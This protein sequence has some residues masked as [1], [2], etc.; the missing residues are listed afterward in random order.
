MMCEMSTQELLSEFR[1][2]ERVEQYADQ[3]NTILD[4]AFHAFVIALMMILS[5]LIDITPL[6]SKCFEIVGS[7]FM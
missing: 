2:I 4:I 5:E 6:L 3:N 1:K 7:K